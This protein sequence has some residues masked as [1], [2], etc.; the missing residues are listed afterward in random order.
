MQTYSSLAQSRNFV[1]HRLEAGPSAFAARNQ[2]SPTQ[3]E[4]ILRQLREIEA[5]QERA[6]AEPAGFLPL[7]RPLWHG[8]QGSPSDG[9][10]AAVPSFS[11]QVGRITSSQP[12]KAKPIKPKEKGHDAQP[13]VLFTTGF[14]TLIEDANH[15]LRA[16]SIPLLSLRIFS[17][18]HAAGRPFVTVLDSQTAA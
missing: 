9:L 5:A 14:G 8:E 10:S 6:S 3:H 4:L 18:L 2:Q 7:D 12:A 13:R 1:A 17:R 16:K 15:S 11:A